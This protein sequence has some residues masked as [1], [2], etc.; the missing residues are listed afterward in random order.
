MARPAVGYLSFLLSPHPLR[1]DWVVPGD[2]GV[3]PDSLKSSLQIKII[4]IL[5]GI[6]P[7]APCLWTLI[8]PFS[9]GR[10][11]GGSTAWAPLTQRQRATS[12]TTS[13]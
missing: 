11:I 6:G 13:G 12:A 1:L 3:L 7:S 10:V 8:E 9:S 2:S 5:F 4:M